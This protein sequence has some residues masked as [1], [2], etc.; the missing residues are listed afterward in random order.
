VMVLCPA[1]HLPPS[2]DDATLYRGADEFLARP[3]RKQATATKLLLLQATQKKFR[4]LSIHP[5][6]C[7][8]NDLH[9]KKKN[10]DLPVVFFS[11]FGLRTYQH[12]CRFPINCA[13]NNNCFQEVMVLCPATH[14][15]PSG[16]DT[17][18]Y[19][20]LPYHVLIY[21]TAEYTNMFKPF[22]QWFSLQK[23]KSHVR[24]RP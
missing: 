7:G 11:R 24:R 8:S 14:L 19:W 6:L 22:L 23:S 15:L 18:L 21:P 3:G 9:F 13:L 12:P 2:G 10:G 16:D 20:P 17:T 4:M 1:T 5:G